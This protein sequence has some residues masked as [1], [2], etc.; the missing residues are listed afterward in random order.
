M[1]NPWPATYNIVE[2]ALAA[3]SGN[4]GG[5]FHLDTGMTGSITSTANTYKY[6][7]TADDGAIFTLASG[8]SFTDSG[9]TFKEN[10][11]VKGTI[12]CPKCSASFTNSIF[13]DTVGG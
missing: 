5:G 9:S 8:M 12:Y 1:W 6:C 2:N 4:M 7:Y 13:K 10:A 3:G 11:G